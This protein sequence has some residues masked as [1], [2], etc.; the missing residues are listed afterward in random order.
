[1]TDSGATGKDWS[2]EENDLIVADYFAMLQQELAGAAYVKAHHRRALA[3][4]TGRSEGSIE[5]KH[6]NVSEVLHQL[7]LPM[8]RGYLPRANIQGSLFDAMER[9]LKADITSIVVPAGRLQGVAEEHHLYVGPAPL[10][11]AAGPG[12]SPEMDRLIK[13][14]DPSERDHRNKLLGDAGEELVFHAERKRLLDEGRA[15]LSKKV[16][17]TAKEDG[18]GAGFDIKSYSRNG[19]DRLIEVKT[20]IGAQRTPFFITRNEYDVSEERRDAYHLLRLYDF[21]RDPK[22]FELKPPLSEVLQLDTQ[23]YRASFGGAA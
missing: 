15:D 1:M 7:G 14:Y 21:A 19:E 2:D 17:W 22:A 20:T 12:R 10:L 6:C 11:G 5:F 18:D 16:R 23:L 9:R 13:K 3:A 8:I 4:Q